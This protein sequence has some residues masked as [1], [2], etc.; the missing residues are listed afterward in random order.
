M[1]WCFRV[2]QVLDYRFHLEVARASMNRRFVDLTQ[3]LGDQMIPRARLQLADVTTPRPLHYLQLVI[4]EHR[5]IFAAIDRSDIAGAH[6]AMRS[7]LG[8][9]LK[10][11]RQ[12]DVPGANGVNRP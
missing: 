8:N 5:R 10:R 1:S 7:H 2:P 4:G 11:R 3:T 9:S 12:S 6:S